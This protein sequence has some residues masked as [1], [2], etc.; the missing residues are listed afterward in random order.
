MSN[1]LTILSWLLFALMGLSLLSLLVIMRQQ[2]RKKMLTGVQL[3][4][5]GRMLVLHVQRHRGLC[6]AS[7]GGP[8]KD[9]EKLPELRARIM[10]DMERLAVLDEWLAHNQN[11]QGI[12]AH[13]ASLSGRYLNMNF[14]ACFDQHCRLVAA[15][16]AL[17]DECAEHYCLITH[18]SREQETW[19]EFL[20][21]GELMG[22]CRALGMHL[23][24]SKLGE[25]SGERSRSMVDKNL[26]AISIL[27]EKPN[28]SKKI[29]AKQQAELEHFVAFVREQL[30]D[31]RRVISASQYFTV[32]S[33]AM[34]I[35][36]Q[37]FDKEILTLL[38][39]VS[40]K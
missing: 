40:S 8:L 15:L 1:P 31:M 28:C 2:Q 6:A 9:V 3:L 18:Y 11:W 39:R 29:E 7:G 13:W 30:F 38:H 16:L 19:R 17:L 5:A 26:H 22:Q 20:Y 10:S 14:E 24:S 37:A 32:V 35:I 25:A 12:T 33:E 34:D 23:L 27:L 21:L 36:Y 4:Q